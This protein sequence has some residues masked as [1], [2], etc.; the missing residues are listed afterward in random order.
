MT[1]FIESIRQK[2]SRGFREIPIE[3]KRILRGEYPPFVVDAR[4]NSLTGGIP[5]FM[6]HSVQAD[7][8]RAKLEYLRVNGYKT[9]NMKEYLQ[10]LSS[11][12]VPDV[13]SVLLTFDDGDSSLYRVAYLFLREYGFHAVAFVAPYFMREQPDTSVEKSWCSWAQILEMDRSG[14]IDI[15]SH[16]FYHDRVFI[17][18]HLVDFYHPR[19][20]QNVL[21]LDIPW[22]GEGE[23]YTN[24]LKWGTPIYQHASRF[25]G[26]RRLM[27]DEKIRQSCIDWV[28][29]RGGD[30]CFEAKHW[31]RDLT[32]YFHSVAA[33]MKTPFRYETEQEQTERMR[34]GLALAKTVLEDRLNKSILYLCY[35][36][37]DACEMAVS[38]SKETGYLCGFWWDVAT[39]Y[40]RG[41]LDLRY[42]IRRVKDDYLM[43]LPG[44]GRKSLA[45]IFREKF[46]RRIRTLDLY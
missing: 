25:T 43:R 23:S 45:E 1:L 18:P 39:G 5:V 17:Q 28:D 9:L 19:F 41:N 38:I 24:D 35:P 26:Y 8:F 15:Q 22:I 16:T 2:V 42:H 30:K 13:P 10:Y 32:K 44:K 31:K 33:G 7:D 11:G 14:T 46:Y 6:F 37:G 34:K 3:A 40:A 21:G 27:D 29:S 36:Y 4:C 20:R 12:D